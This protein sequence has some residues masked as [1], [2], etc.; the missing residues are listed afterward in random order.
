MTA[1]EPRGMTLAAKAIDGAASL[2]SVP[3]RIYWLAPLVAALDARPG[4]DA[5]E[6]ARK[7][8]QVAA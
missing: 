7:A 8:R 6:L 5:R 1:G 3:V 2:Q 4:G